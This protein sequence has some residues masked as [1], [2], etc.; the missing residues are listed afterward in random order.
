MASRTPAP[1]YVVPHDPG[2]ADQYAHEA[3]AI[4]RLPS[5]ALTA[6]PHLPVARSAA[7]IVAKQS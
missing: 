6:D 3:A 1:P 2:W 5:G 7:E 4:A